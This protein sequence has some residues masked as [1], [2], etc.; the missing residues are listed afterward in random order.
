[1]YSYARI[2]V[3]KENLANDP[4][5]GRGSHA[6][7]FPILRNEWVKENL[8]NDP[9]YG[10]GSHALIFPIL[11]NEWVKEKGES[12]SGFVGLSRVFV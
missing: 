8:A 11:R 4:S 6:L 12:V 3:V 1:M 7:I 5:Y 2:K 9:S 10:R